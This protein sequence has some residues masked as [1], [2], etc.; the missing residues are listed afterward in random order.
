MAIEFTARWSDPSYNHGS[1]FDT[2]SLSW[3]AAGGL[4]QGEV[5][6]ALNQ[7]PL[8]INLPYTQFDPNGDSRL[9][10]QS[11]NIRPQGFRLWIVT[12]NF[13]VPVNGTFDDD[14]QPVK[15]KYQWNPIVHS[16]EV[17]RDINGNPLLNSGN[18]PYRVSVER[19]S[20]QLTVVRRE[21]S[22]SN[23]QAL[24]YANAVNSDNF[25]GAAP[26]TVQCKHIKPSGEFTTDSSFV[27]VEYLFE[28]RSEKT[29]G[30]KPFWSRTLNAAYH[31]FAVKRDATG[32]STGEYVWAEIRLNDQA[33]TRPSTPILLD[34]RGF[35]TEQ[36]KYVALGGT[37]ADQAHIVGREFEIAPDGITSFIRY[38]HDDE[39]PFS[40][41]GLT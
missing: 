22:F 7:I 8:Y 13:A 6:A 31:V 9:L 3:D 25:Y 20:I 27:D 40:A 4:I 34:R 15:I 41:L 19:Q 39:L 30:L 23:V 5:K 17:D 37:Y 35:P 1:P 10:V 2:A 21:S 33:R 18:E 24:L 29:W 36:E 14:A 28:F 16:V 12:A 38:Q 26:G 32:A 11:I